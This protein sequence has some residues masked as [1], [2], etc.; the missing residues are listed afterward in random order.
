MEVYLTLGL[1]P[2]YVPSPPQVQIHAQFSLHAGSTLLQSL[3]LDTG[4]HTH[5]QSQVRILANTCR[6]KTSPHGH[7]HGHGHGKFIKTPNLKRPAPPGSLPVR[8]SHPNQ[9]LSVDGSLRKEV[10]PRRS[11]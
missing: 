4:Q 9:T 2:R 1:S 11:T 10:S 3:A 6:E 8:P 7:G 5:I